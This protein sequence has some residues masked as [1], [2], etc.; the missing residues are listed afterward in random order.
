LKKNGT[1]SD[2][3]HRIKVLLIEDRESDIRYVKEIL[4]EKNEA[5]KIGDL[6]DLETANR[7]DKA[8]QRLAK[9]DVDVILTNLTLPDSTGLAT[10]K[11]LYDHASDVAIVILSSDDPKLAATVVE[12]GAQDYL[13]KSKLNAN[14]LPR[15][16][17]YAFERKRIQKRIYQAEQRYRSVF[18]NS[19]VA[20]ILADS[21]GM[22]V[23]WNQ[24]SERLLGMA[25]EDLHLKPLQSLYPVKE[26]EKLNLPENQR[27]LSAQERFE[28]KIVRQDGTMIDVDVSMSIQKNLAGKETGSILIVRDITEQKRLESLKD[29]FLSTVSHELRTPL[30]IIREAVSQMA[31]GILGKVNAKQKRFLDISLENLDRLARIVNELLDISKLEVGSERLD[32]EYIDIAM[33]LKQICE[34]FE[35]RARRRNVR[36]SFKTSVPKVE[37]FADRDKIIQVMTNLMSN[38]LKFTEQGTIQIVLGDH[39]DR[40]ECS[41]EDTG[42]GIAEEDLPKIFDKFQQFGRVAG[43]GDQG[44]GLGLA[45]CKGIIEMHKGHIW[46]ESKWAQGTTMTFTLPKFTA[47]QLCVETISEKINQALQDKATFAVIML[48]IHCKMGHQKKVEAHLWAKLFRLYDDWIARH[49]NQKHEVVFRN[50]R[51]IMLYLPGMARESALMVAGRMRQI[52]EDAVG[53]WGIY[54]AVKL[55]FSVAAFPEDGQ[56]VDSLIQKLG[57]LRAGF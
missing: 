30:A 23:S 56:M 18:E 29:E 15:I 38:A 28:T 24:F 8:L 5:V 40:I 45:I 50:D 54:E 37:V 14:N 3:P 1:E 27:K 2:Q 16:L 32:K 47:E 51:S 10:F 4:S 48:N 36:I 31:E 7:L 39:P 55:D 43:P 49:L 26:W 19:A 20:I 22:I 25:Y 57:I 35:A 13:F 46:A 9:G 52:L 42:R 6:F 53:K 34:S 44:T 33:V 11:R 12:Q 21:R 41:V 17:Q